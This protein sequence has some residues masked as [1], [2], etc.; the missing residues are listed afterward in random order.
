MSVII[1]ILLISAALALT[2]FLLK[3]EVNLGFIMLMDSVFIVLI[4]KIPVSSA[5]HY[6]FIGAFSKSSLKLNLILI[7]IMM[8]ENIMRN[9]GMIRSMVDSLKELV[10][11]NRMAAGLLPMVIGLLP[12]PGGA[13]FSCPMVEEVTKENAESLNKSFINYWFRHVWMDG[14]ILYPGVILAAELLKVSVISLFL[15]IIPF[16]IISLIIGI[17]F[18]LMHVKKEVVNK[19]K[20]VKESLK[21]FI[22]SMLPIIAV[23]TVY[24]ALLN[25]TDYSLEI[26]SGGTVAALFILKRYTFAQIKKSAKE[27]FPVKLI[28]II[29]GVMVFNEILKYSGAIT[30][31]SGLMNTYGIPVVL[32]FILLPLLGSFSSGIMVNF[33]SLVFPILIPF[34]LGNSLWLAAATYVAGYI[35]NMITPLHLCAIMT[36]DYFKSPLTRLLKK[37][38]VAEIPLFVLTVAVLVLFT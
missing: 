16:M 5:F 30:G 13:R 6:A 28:F 24:I 4:A 26:A 25:F 36:T 35:G 32:L 8:L 1:N 20:P 2:V 19:T 9:S 37:V 33:V 34:G 7:L 14:F 3:K 23:I 29:L 18:G 12:S 17:L 15:H 22:I 10:G 38:T 31:L 21:V 27:A 11:S